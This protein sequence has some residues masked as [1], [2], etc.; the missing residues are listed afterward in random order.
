MSS[1][2]RPSRQ[3]RGFGGFPQKSGGMIGIPAQFFSD[4]LP[5]I[6]DLNELKV[7]VYCFWALHQREGEYRY[8]RLIDLQQ[9]ETLLS[10]LSESVTKRPKALIDALER[11]TARGTLLHIH[12][13]TDP[14]EDLYF[15]NTARGRKAVQALER[16]EWQ[17]GTAD[18]PVG[19]IIERPNIFVLYEQNIGPLTPLL[20]EVLRDAE[21]DY[22]AE[23]IVEAFQVAVQNN[24]RSWRYVEA[25]L[26][27]WMTDGRGGR[28]SNSSRQSTDD[29]NPYLRDDYFRRKH[30]DQDD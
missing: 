9:D 17:P 22:P 21:H 1:S 13:P 15:M 30:E 16:G 23:W 4:L 19:L 29:V 8:L 12:L 26:K 10:A 7:T 20:S 2:S 11:A 25:I 5:L 24:K 18:Q 3:M 27:S 14:A 6:D 28:S